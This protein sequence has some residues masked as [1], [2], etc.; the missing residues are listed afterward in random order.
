M[1][2]L[3]SQVDELLGSL[4]GASKAAP[5]QQWLMRLENL[6]DELL[7]R[8]ASKLH[9]KQRWRAAVSY[10]AVV[11]AVVA[12]W[13]ESWQ[14]S[15]GFLL[16]DAIASAL[17]S[18]A[19]GSA[20]TRALSS[21][22]PAL[23]AV[24]QLL[25]KSQDCDVAL[26]A[27]VRFGVVV[28][29]NHLTQRH[30][31]AQAEALLGAMVAFC[32]QR[33]QLRGRAKWTQFLLAMVY[34]THRQDVEQALRC[35][36]RALSDRAEVNDDRD[37]D[38]DEEEAGHGVFL[39]WYAVVL[40]QNGSR[41]EAL[42]VLHQCL[43]YEYEPVSSLTLSAWAHLQD[44]DLHEAANALQ[45]AME[46]D[47]AQSTSMFNHSLL[48]GRMNQFDA[49]QQ[50]LQYYIQ[51]T[52]L[53]EQDAPATIAS[54]KRKRSSGLKEDTTLKS[55]ATRT[56]FSES[57]IAALFPVQRSDVTP[58]MIHLQSASAAIENRK[59]SEL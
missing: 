29:A 12:Q 31:P 26:K 38:A 11:G 16:D 41:Q 42:A 44:S 54:K 43:R 14:R 37:V 27:V 21:E 35:F 36:R 1:E 8:L 39:Y 58:D 23:R 6:K 13:P 28:A 47:F 3:A 4:H 9:L 24:T 45:R 5:E 20:N 52:S 51:A 18:E 46:I 33:P 55:S 15:P 40:F 56:V 2:L 57:D 10:C 30:S 19:N 59:F 48:L 7:V 53:T 49:Q 32:Q 22:T 50:M 25:T 17:S 34:W